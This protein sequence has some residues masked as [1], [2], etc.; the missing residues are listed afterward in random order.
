MYRNLLSLLLTKVEENYH[1]YLRLVSP[2]CRKISQ[3]AFVY[4]QPPPLDSHADSETE[5]DE[6]D[7]RIE[8]FN[9]K[10]FLE[11]LFRYRKIINIGKRLLLIPRKGLLWSCYH[12]D[13]ALTQVMLNTCVCVNEAEVENALSMACRSG[14][15]KTAKWL[16]ANFDCANS[17]AIISSSKSNN[18]ELVTL[19]TEEVIKKRKRYLGHFDFQ[20][21]KNVI[22]IASENGYVAIIRWFKELTHRLPQWKEEYNFEKMDTNILNSAIAN[23]HISIVEFILKDTTEF[24]LNQWMLRICKNQN[25]AMVELLIKLGADDWNVGLRGACEG[26][27]L[28]IVKLMLFKG[29]NDF[30]MGLCLACYG[31]IYDYY[32]ENY[33]AIIQLMIDHGATNFNTALVYLFTAYEETMKDYLERCDPQ[34]TS[35]KNFSA[36]YPI[37]ARILIENG[38]D[39]IEKCCRILT[40]CQCRDCLTNIFKNAVREIAMKKTDG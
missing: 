17:T 25:I 30:N 35:E 39:N 2:W 28:E 24:E 23:G 29:A 21:W 15:V 34:N 40:E 10:H 1:P 8:K 18:F 3:K 20:S 31:M 12:D 37:V 5:F 6:Y 38:A 22:D 32:S 26:G 13:I 36:K 11:N 16:L 33:I 9:L 19:I 7:A 14:S 4:Y 27:S